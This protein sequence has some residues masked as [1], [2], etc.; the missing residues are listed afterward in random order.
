MSCRELVTTIAAAKGFKETV[1]GQFVDVVKVPN[2]SETP[3]EV[4]LTMAGGR[5]TFTVSAYNY[6]ASCGL[7]APVP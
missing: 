7:T 4:I 1:P 6:E 3:T 5:R 2:G